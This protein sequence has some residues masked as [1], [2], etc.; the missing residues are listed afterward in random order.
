MSLPRSQTI[1]RARALAG[2]HAGQL[3]SKS[4][5][6]AHVADS[7]TSYQIDWL[8]FGECV[9]IYSTD[10]AAFCAMAAPR[11]VPPM[12]RGALCVSALKGDLSYI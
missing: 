5:A 3:H 8:C 4:R 11:D 10:C 1:L 2:H 9:C 7:S 12:M 6:R